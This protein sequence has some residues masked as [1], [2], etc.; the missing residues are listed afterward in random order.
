MSGFVDVFDTDYGHRLG[1]RAPTF[2]AV[3]R[4]AVS[5]GVSSIVETGCVRKEGNW[6]GDGQSTIILHHYAKY[7]GLEFVTVDLDEEAT[8]LVQGL[9]PGV[10]TYCMDSVRYLQ[11]RVSPIDLL[12]LDSFDVDMK[13]PHEA[14]QHALFELCAAMPKLH[15]GS[16]VFVDDSPTT[17]LGDVG[18]KG[19]Y[20]HRYFKQLGVHPFT[21]GYQSAW[22]MP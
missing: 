3:I 12:Y 4:E 6:E 1:V 9:C 18:G 21:F 14:A 16:I 5:R 11:K 17:T 20:V 13:E 10:T 15:K 7:N 8:S 22:I 19:R 2:R